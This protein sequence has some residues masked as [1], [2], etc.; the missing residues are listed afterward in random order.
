M[1]P[2]CSFC[3]EPAPVAWY[4]GPDFRSSVDDSAKVTSDEAYLACET[5][6]QLIESDDREALARRSVRRMRVLGT[7]LPDEAELLTMVRQS[8]ESFWHA[9][10]K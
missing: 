8:N 2:K 9:R 10:D 5:C 1:Y 6:R 3:G 4:Q 7:R